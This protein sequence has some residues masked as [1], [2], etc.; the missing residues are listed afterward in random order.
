M[1]LATNRHLRVF[2]P[3]LYH[4]VTQRICNGK[5]LLDPNCPQLK[6][7]I[8]GQLAES[9]ARYNVS[10][11]GLQFMSDH[12]HALYGISCPYKF[13]KFLAHFHA[14]LT[15]AYNKLQAAASPQMDYKPVALWHEMKWMPV[16]TDEASVSWR[17][18]YLMR[19]AVVA[20]LVDHPIEFPGA[21]TIDAM[22]DGTPMVGK[23][24]DCATKYRDS[25]RLSGTLPDNEYERSLEVTVTPPSCWAHLSP[26]E[27]RQQYV[28]IADS[29]ARVPLAELRRGE[30]GSPEQEGNPEQGGSSQRDGSP[31][32]EGSPEQGGSPQRDGS[33]EQRAQ[34]TG[35][36][37][38][39]GGPGLPQ[40]ATSEGDFWEQPA[41]KRRIPPRRTESGEP[42][43][44]GPPKPK[45]SYYTADGKRKKRPLILAKSSTVCEA[46]EVAYG[47]WV[48]QYLLAKSECRQAMEVLP[49]GLRA[50]GLAIPRFMLLG[51]MPYPR[52]E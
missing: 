4:E 21:S 6:V 50:P 3:N 17:L 52:T 7:A 19:Q 47:E 39:C 41:G 26:H 18:A 12:F 20:N 48:E 25:R 11:I 49:A 2:D 28:A 32:Q 9:L 31:E 45:P 22:I 5:F 35:E 38:A 30:L 13:A 23:T 42:F 14:G 37:Q 34:R 46:Y 8:Y 15:R 36:Q 10:L 29:V 51:S 33:P 16:A 40:V 43:E 24:Y 27:L 1:A 44:A